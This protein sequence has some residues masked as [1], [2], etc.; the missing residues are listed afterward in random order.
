MT[1]P[2]LDFSN[3]WNYVLWNSGVFMLSFIPNSFIEWLAH[4][5]VLHSK[6]IVKFAYEEHD[7]THH[8]IYKADDSFSMP[9]F[10]YGVDFHVRDWVL[11]LIVVIPAWTGLEILVGRPMLAGGILST[12]VWLQMF[13][14]IHGR[15]HS[16]RGSWFERTR[17]FCAL[18]AHHFAHHGDTG[19]NFNVAF[20]PPFADF[21][22]RTLARRS[23]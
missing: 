21:F 8:V 17:Y 19:K 13:N 11:F 1:F 6:A 22:L 18:R 23:K 16:P 10:D 12:L 3:P 9:G 4:R 7:R 15:F 14:F 2:S 20:F 5:F